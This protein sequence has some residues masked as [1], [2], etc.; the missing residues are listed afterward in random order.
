M[1]ADALHVLVLAGGPD[2][3]REVSLQS[4]AEVSRA[5]REAGHR[6]E[7]HDISERDLSALERF[8]DWPGDVIFPVLHGPWGEGGGL[9]RLL[10]ERGLPYVG[11]RGPA[12]ALCMDKARAK[13]AM[14][15][16][17]TSSTT[18]TSSASSAKTAADLPTPPH[19]VVTA[20]EPITLSPPVVIKPTCEG[21]SIGMAICHDEAALAAAQKELSASYGT[22]LVERYI[23]GRE[24]TVGVLEGLNGRDDEL[25][26]LPPIEIVPAASYYDFH[27]KYDSEQTQYR[28]DI[29]LPSATLDRLRALAVAVHRALGARAPEP[30]GLHCGRRRPAVDSGNQYAA[31]LYDAFA[32]AD[33]R[34]P[35]GA[36]DA[37]A[38]GPPG[39]PCLG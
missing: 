17:S 33:G 30:G 39:R 11:T 13:A 10:D 35:A 15:T 9:Q 34:G 14:T 31:W 32:A 27:A 29:D 2:R 36:G 20:D 25:T 21:S 37:G 12:A 7:Q 22:L 5:L 1:T 3:E 6:V 24:V 23:V 8:A 38:G 18:S 4:G 16:S 28:F 19:Q 26:A